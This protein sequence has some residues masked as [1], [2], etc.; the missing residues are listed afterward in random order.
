M[1]GMRIELEET[2]RMHDT[3]QFEKHVLSNGIIVW[4]QKSI[5][6]V[7]S[8]GHLGVF[9]N[10]IGSSSDPKRQEGL[11]HFVEHMVFRGSIKNPSK[12]KLID[13]FV[14][15]GGIIGALTNRDI[16]KYWAETSKNKF[17]DAVSVMSEMLSEPIFNQDDVEIE[18][19]VINQEIRDFK[20]SGMRLIVKHT[21]QF[22]FGKKHPFAIEAIGYTSSI[23]KIT[24]ASLSDFFEKY[25]HAGNMEIVCGG[26]FSL[27]ENAIEILEKSFGSIPV[28]KANAPRKSPA[29]FNLKGLREF[30]DRRYEADMLCVAF[31]F[32]SIPL[33]KRFALRILIE[34]LADNFGSPLMKELRERLGLVYSVDSR[35]YE[36]CGIMIAGMECSI[37]ARNFFRAQDVFFETLKN[38]S[39]DYVVRHIKKTREL[40]LID[41]RLPV[42]ACGDLPEEVV[43][44]GRPYSYREWERMEDAVTLDEI[45]HWRDLLLSREPLVLH[46]ISKK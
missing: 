4:F 31:L 9:L 39:S 8:R 23:E 37:Q 30:I 25:Y 32:P 13:P 12:E 17:F 34:S 43:R 5:I 6:S 22:I 2:R 18:R 20:I 21:E 24:K 11:A 45:F 27:I 40:R 16:T 1:R 15:G 28:K 46:F 3:A 36:N 35:F 10:G 38:L 14:S 29:D 33:E 44:R 42:S 19:G 7:D 41:F 26:S